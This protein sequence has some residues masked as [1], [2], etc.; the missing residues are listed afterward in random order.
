[1]I[2]R[3]IFKQVAAT[4][5]VIFL[6]T[7]CCTGRHATQWEYKVAEPQGNP[8]NTRQALEPFLNDMAKEG[9]IFIERDSTGWCYFKRPKQ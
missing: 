1:M 9:W 6:L 8:N 3:Q 2:M 7:G 5:P 4:I